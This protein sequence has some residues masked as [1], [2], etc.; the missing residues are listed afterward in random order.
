MTKSAPAYCPVL[1]V[2]TLSAPMSPPPSCPTAG[3]AGFA[4]IAGVAR[5]RT[6]LQHVSC[7]TSRQIRR[8]RSPPP[9]LT[10]SS[11]GE[12]AMTSR[13]PPR[14]TRYP[15]Q[16][17]A[18]RVRRL[19]ARLT[20]THH[21]CSLPYCGRPPSMAEHVRDNQLQQPELTKVPSSNPNAITSAAKRA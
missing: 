20:T 15:P 4:A 2:V 6:T 5:S 14:A 11:R 8:H 21:H 9:N 16:P 12:L 17:A 19:A 13:P 1:P 7:G 18:R 3:A 10:S